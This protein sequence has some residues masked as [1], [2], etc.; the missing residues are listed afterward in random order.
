MCVYVYV[1]E[2]QCKCPKNKD[3][4]RCWVGFLQVK[5]LVG[6]VRSLWTSWVQQNQH[7]NWKWTIGIYQIQPRLYCTILEYP[8][9]QR[10]NLWFARF[11]I[12]DSQILCAMFHLKMYLLHFLRETVNF[13]GDV[14]FSWAAVYQS[15]YISNYIYIFIDLHLLYMMFWDI[16]MPKSVICCTIYIWLLDNL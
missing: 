12:K 4:R 1:S 9:Y 14:P 13:N 16:Y 3:F 15:M 10:P 5:W 11:S 8:E 7:G 2:L 6:T